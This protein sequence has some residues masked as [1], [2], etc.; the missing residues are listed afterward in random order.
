MAAEV[1]DTVVYSCKAPGLIRC[2][3]SRIVFEVEVAAGTILVWQCPSCKKRIRIYLGFD[4][5]LDK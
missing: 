1:D 2:E 5:S 4:I 3:C